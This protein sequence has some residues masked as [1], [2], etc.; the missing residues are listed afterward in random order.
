MAWE[1]IFATEDLGQILTSVSDNTAVVACESVFAILA[2]EG[3]P[4]L[5]RIGARDYV[6]PEPSDLVEDIAKIQAVKK[7]FLRKFW[8]VSGREIV[9]EAAQQRLEAVSIFFYSIDSLQRDMLMIVFAIFVGE[10]GSG[11][12]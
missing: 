6:F 2:H 5:E 8:K 9:R 7:S 11:N 3:C 10:A 4:E 12:G 1:A